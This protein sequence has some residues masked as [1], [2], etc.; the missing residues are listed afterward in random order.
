[1]G[2]SQGHQKISS[3]S[4]ASPAPQKPFNFSG[5]KTR[6]QTSVFSCLCTKIDDNPHSNS[7]LLN[8]SYQ[9][10]LTSLARGYLARRLNTQT[11]KVHHNRISKKE[12]TNYSEIAKSNCISTDNTL[13]HD[14]KINYQI[15]KNKPASY[16]AYRANEKTT[17]K[18][19]KKNPSYEKTPSETGNSEITEWVKKSF[20][21]PLK[22]Y[23]K[24][25]NNKKELGADDET[26]EEDCDDLDL[27]NEKTDCLG[28]KMSNGS[29]YYGE[30]K[31]GKPHGM[32]VE[33]WYNGKIY[34]GTYYNGKYSGQGVLVWPDKSMYKG[35]FVNNSMQ[36]YGVFKW[37]N[38]NLY[39]GM[40]NKSKM[41]GEGK[42][43]WSNG[44]KFIG[45]YED[46]L[47]HGNGVF[48]WTDGREIKG[49][50]RFDK[51]QVCV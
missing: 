37:S 16:S 14:F 27:S 19:N 41:H 50:W 45:E 3:V 35:G 6:P 7:L 29:V 44:N 33:K 43:T 39:E 11:P 48:F 28:V 49:V 2:N 4:K 17:K 26:Y 31:D 5:P 51:I 21:N 1:M 46:G 47:K 18:I 15:S 25:K 20:E 9:L 32:G 38:G 30:L 10:K 12:S 8:P 22:Y 36:G 24:P 13:C 34:E 42:F 40:W 23:C